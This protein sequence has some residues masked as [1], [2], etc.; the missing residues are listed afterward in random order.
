LQNSKWRTQY[1]G[2]HTSNNQFY[3]HRKIVIDLKIWEKEFLGSLI[4]NP[5]SDLQNSKW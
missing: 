3:G 2:H 1:G 5:L 4:T